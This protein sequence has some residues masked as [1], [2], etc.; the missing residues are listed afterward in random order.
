MSMFAIAVDGASKGN[1]GAAGIGVVVYNETGEI[2]AEI[3]EYIGEATNNVAE[4]SALLR[5]LRE[6]L[7]LGG[8][9]IRISTDSELMVKQ[10]VGVYKVKSPHLVAYYQ[11]AK[12]LLSQ[13]KDAKIR[14]VPREQ[15][16]LAD[17]LASGAATRKRDLKARPKPTSVDSGDW[18]AV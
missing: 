3:S 15:N 1:P 18:N 4:Y 14:H 16:V 9:S 12:S 11:D 6:V 17:K 2:L 7:S 10:I 13:F 8:T 5:G